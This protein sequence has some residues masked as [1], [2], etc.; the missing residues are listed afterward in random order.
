MQYNLLSGD[1]DSS[2][3]KRLNKYYHMAMSIELKKLS[4]ETI[5]LEI[6]L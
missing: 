1:G 2:V 3:S 5:F 4:V 6:M